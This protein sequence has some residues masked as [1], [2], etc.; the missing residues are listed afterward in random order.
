M[1]RAH[2]KSTTIKSITQT[3]NMATVDTAISHLENDFQQAL[4]VLDTDI[5]KLLSYR[6]LMTKP[7][8]KKIWSTSSANKLG[9]LETGVGRRI[10]KPNNTIAFIT[11]NEI[12][13]D[14]RKDVTHRKFVCSVRPVNKEKYRTRFTVGRDKID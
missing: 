9:R 7:K 13:H 5:G 11:R 4:A 14:R 12:P 1:A 6:Q 2:T 8:F 3:G 10:K